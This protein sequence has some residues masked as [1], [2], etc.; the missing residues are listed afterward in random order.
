[1]GR[2]KE[3]QNRI[4]S[5]RRADLTVWQRMVL[6]V[7]GVYRR[8]ISPLTKPACR[9]RPT[10]SDYA[11]EAVR[12]FGVVKGLYLASLR[13]CRCHPFNPGGI[14]PVPERRP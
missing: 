11:E 12:R 14:D 1:M 2:K 6:W 3:E 4:G 13:I 5:E 7:L 8:C 9:F 10:C